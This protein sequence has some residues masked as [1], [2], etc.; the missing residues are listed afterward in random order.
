MQELEQASR[1]QH[2]GRFDQMAFERKWRAAIA[3]GA[4]QVLTGT[5]VHSLDLEEG[6]K[7]GQANKD[8]ERLLQVNVKT[9]R[10][11]AHTCLHQSINKLAGATQETVEAVARLAIKT[12]K[13]DLDR[14]NHASCLQVTGNNCTINLARVN[15]LQMHINDWGSTVTAAVASARSQRSLHTLQQP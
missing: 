2:G 12:C 14:L 1:I 11:T 10:R 3:V 6:L 7:T 5:P 9:K 15:T 4:Q 13:P 8:F